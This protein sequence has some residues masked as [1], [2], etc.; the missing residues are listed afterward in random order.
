MELRHLRYFQVLA[1]ELHFGHAARR[2]FISQ[3]P[4]SRQ[5]KEL[6]QELA[7][8]LFLR[9][10]KRVQLTDAGKYF[11]QEVHGIFNKLE[12]AKVQAGRI[13]HALAGVIK[14]GYIS[15]IDKKKLG[16]LTRQIQLAHP[17]IK[18]QLFELPT[19]KQIQALE[20]GRL[21]VG[22]IRGPNP[23]A[24]LTAEKLYE[25]GFCLAMPGK[26]ALP[27][28]ISALEQL[29]F[30]S[31]H[32]SAV[33]VYHAQMLA[34]AAQMGFT[35]QLRY[36]CNNISSILELVHLG[37]GISI[38]PGAVKS[39]YDHLDIQFYTPALSTILT[40]VM[41]AAQRAQQHPAFEAIRALIIPLFGTQK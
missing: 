10:N 36:E 40:Q 9:D 28:D 39:Q 12:T 15:S 25:D 41:L 22:I 13:H 8:T 18:T 31:Y 4:L 6:E 3:P 17:F 37:A 24:A 38:V 30:I 2:L 1:E 34:F 27:N 16:E 11:L 14:I 32:V 26:T 7:V 21:D 20:A 29:P 33:P 35:P 23:S 5:I 19:A